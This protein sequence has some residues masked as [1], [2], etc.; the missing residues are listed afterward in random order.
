MG[1]IYIYLIETKNE[2]WYNI[3][4]QKYPTLNKLKKK[5]YRKLKNKTNINLNF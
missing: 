1:A 4:K 5:K 2:M 3:L